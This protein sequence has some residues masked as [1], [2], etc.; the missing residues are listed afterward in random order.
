MQ[1]V[2]ER[3]NV[4][5]GGMVA[6][7]AFTIQAGAHIMAVLSGLYK[8]PVD[9]MVREYTTN[10]YDAWLALKRVNP[11]AMYKPCELHLPTVLSPNLIFK[12]YGI[13]MSYDQ[14]WDVYAQYGNSTKNGNNDEVGG[15]GLGSKTAFCY[16]HG[17]QWTIESRYK[18]DHMIFLA[19]LGSDSIPQLTHVS[20]M[21]MAKGEQD[22]VTIRIPILRNDFN[23]VQVAAAK[24]V[25]HFP[26]KIDVLNAEREI[27]PLTYIVSHN[28]GTSDAWG[29]LQRTG[30]YGS[31]YVTVVMGNVPYPVDLNIVGS[32]IRND[33]T[34]TFS[35]G[36]IP[37][38]I[39]QY[40]TVMLTV[41]IGSV[42]I[43]PSRDD[44][45]Y[46]DRTIAALYHA[47]IRFSTDLAQQVSAKLN[48]ATSEYNA[49]ETFI[50]LYNIVGLAHL[51]GTVTYNGRVLP[52]NNTIT[53]KA[54]D[55]SAISSMTTYEL[56]S[57][58]RATPE[59]HDNIGFVSPTQNY[60]VI[61][62]DLVK[63]SVNIARGYIYTNYVYRTSTGRPAKYGHTIGHVVLIK[64]SMTFQQIADF[65]G[66]MPL[67]NI[68]L[69]SS[70]SGKLKI[71]SGQKGNDALYRFDGGKV[72]GARVNVPTG[73][74]FY[75]LE[76]KQDTYSKRWTHARY[77]AEDI[78]QL[79]NLANTYGIA[80]DV[81]YG[82][83]SGQ[84]SQFDP[85]EW[86]DLVAELKKRTIAK[87]KTN[88]PALVRAHRRTVT[89][90]T[91]DAVR[92]FIL[93]KLSDQLGTT[94][95][96][97]KEL[98]TILS[99]YR[100]FELATANTNVVS[101]ISALSTVDDAS[102]SIASTFDPSKS[103]K[104]KAENAKIP[105]LNSIVGEFCSKYPMLNLFVNA[106]S[107]GYYDRENLRSQASTR[108]TIVEYINQMEMI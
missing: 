87:I 56:G 66:G 101:I 54:S 90:K 36:K 105:D 84:Q 22:G 80:V 73:G 15:F 103:A 34:G 31:S 42:D 32:K 49:I 43:T 10:M 44:L 13:G 28:I 86:V 91:S 5:M 78:R 30:R 61:V 29:I 23:A 19:F 94:S 18:G 45:K 96:V 11:K 33:S 81:V 100:L 39:I 6:Q 97:G 12:D 40:N 59:V 65:F 21:P 82:I 89:T 26:M 79:M 74:P 107:P 106:T 77:G 93:L 58:R 76:L 7:K 88:L 53:R 16:N 52:A 75:Y 62:D 108:H 64:T 8:N 38:E 92:C 1:V 70:L 68:V 95:D 83:K 63:G 51:A 85:T 27:A 60:K 17:Q 67:D 104:A 98:A 37:W 2:T 46:T 25:P 20:T 99:E 72:W 102:R 3:K 9:A 55:S 50:A 24:Y 69:A 57:Q 48:A 35:A 4:S 71:P 41:P 14:V 47:M